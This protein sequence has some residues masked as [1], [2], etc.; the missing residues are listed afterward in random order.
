MLFSEIRAKNRGIE[1]F[2]AIRNR[3]G[4]RSESQ[5]EC[6]LNWAQYCQDLYHGPDFEKIS[7]VPIENE[8]LYS[9][10][11]FSEFMVALTSLKRNKAPGK[12]CITNED[13]KSLLP[14]ESG[15][16]ELGTFSEMALN[17]LFN[18]IEVFWKFEKIP[19]DL[20]RVILRPF[21]KNIDKDDHDPKNY[22]TISLLNSFFKLYAAIIHK[23]LM[24]KLEN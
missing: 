18:L 8:S 11:E 23:R 19:V 5:K 12:D 17:M 22:R 13:I 9:P 3:D 4:S 21:L 1:T 14:Q 6:L 20:K 7:H 10:I 24:K 2:N 16:F 15:N